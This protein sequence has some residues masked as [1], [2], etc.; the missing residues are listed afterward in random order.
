M[1]FKEW[2]FLR[3]IRI[4]EGCVIGEFAF[5]GCENLY[6]FSVSGGGAEQYC[7]HHDNCTFV[8]EQ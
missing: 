6:I 5:D 4:P 3:Q 8:A 7:A 1:E 2:V